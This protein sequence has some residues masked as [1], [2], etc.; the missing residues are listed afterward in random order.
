MKHWVG[1]A[2]DDVDD[3]G[4]SVSA[5]RDVEENHLIG[6]LLVIADGQLH[7]IAHVPELARFGFAELHTAGHL[8][9][10]HVRQGMTRRASM[11]D[12]RA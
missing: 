5:G 4:A 6:A 3:G 11:E 1:R 8:A 10:M 2:L 12:Y 9:A 7:R